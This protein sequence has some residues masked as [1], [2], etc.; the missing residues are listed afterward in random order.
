MRP[1]L[2]TQQRSD[3]CQLRVGP[4]GRHAARHS[5]EP[6]PCSVTEPSG[7]FVGAQWSQVGYSRFADPRPGCLNPGLPVLQVNDGFATGLAVTTDRRAVSFRPVLTEND[8]RTAATVLFASVPVWLQTTLTCW[9]WMRTA[10]C[11][12]GGPT[13]PASSGWAICANVPAR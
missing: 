6:D 2:G 13:G 10:R 12:R 11:G 4:F 8:R 9:P 5:D 3:I 7:S 1:T